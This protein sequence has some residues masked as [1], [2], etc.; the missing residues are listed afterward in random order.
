M[1]NNRPNKLLKTYGIIGTALFACAG[2]IL[3][4]FLGGPFWIIAGVPIGALC[5]HFIH[6]LVNKPASVNTTHF[7]LTNCIY[8]NKLSSLKGVIYA[9]VIRQ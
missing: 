8:L 7:S 1:K 4:F 6:K 2:G 3:A 9:R 5:G